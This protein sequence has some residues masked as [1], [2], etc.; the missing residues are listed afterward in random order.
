MPLSEIR[1]KIDVIDS[2]LIE[3]LNERAD[4]VHEVGLVKK[5]EGVAIYAPEREEAL[6]RS[7]V[8]KNK[9][10]LPA[11]SVRAIY[12]EIMS[13]SLAL[14]KQLTIAYLGPEATWSHQ[15]ARQKFGASV[16]Y[17]AQSSIAEVFNVVARGKA[18]YG[19]V[20]IENST[21]GAVNYTLDVFMDSELK[22][23]AQFLLKIEN[24]LI[25]K[26]PRGEIR[27]VYSH[28]Q[29]IGQCRQWLRHNLPGVD[30]I[31]VASTTHAAE[32]ASKEPHAAAIAGQ[33]AAEVYGLKIL[34][35]GIQD[36]PDNTTRFLP[37]HRRR[38]DIAHVLRAGQTRRAFFRAR[39]VPTSQDQHEQN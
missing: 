28:P 36:S 33:M 19:V 11:D 15:A 2:K 23:C 1:K 18:D 38:Q 25:S 32:L 3:L 34:E 26:I 13:A 7:L 24:N 8:A 31:E 39:T 30:L 9:G 6:L 10:R 37:A 4:L 14:E 12:R 27:K 22:I 29:V 16:D 35:T 21:E 5:K 20:P 17:A